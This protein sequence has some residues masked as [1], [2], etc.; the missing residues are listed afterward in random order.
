MLLNNDNLHKVIF[1]AGHQFS[2]IFP[3]RNHLK[4]LQTILDSEDLDNNRIY[5]YLK[6]SNVKYYA[7]YSMCLNYL[8]LVLLLVSIRFWVYTRLATSGT[9]Q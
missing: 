6:D 7:L 5:I 9:P 4:V 3:Q 2:R 1:W 8:Y